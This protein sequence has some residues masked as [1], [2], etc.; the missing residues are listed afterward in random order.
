[1]F[2]NLPRAG[3]YISDDPENDPYLKAAHLA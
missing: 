3:G 1:M 2:W